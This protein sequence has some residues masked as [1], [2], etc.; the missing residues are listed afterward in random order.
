MTTPRR[1][2]P[3]LIETKLS[4]MLVISA[5]TRTGIS[6]DYTLELFPDGTMRPANGYYTVE[7]RR[8]ACARAINR[9]SVILAPQGRRWNDVLARV[10][11]PNDLYASSAEADRGWIDDMAKQ[12]KTDK[13]LRL[14]RY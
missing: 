8:A 3:K 2:T 6:L 7:D 5:G 13:D 14:P 11:D 12:M 1:W 10:E 4:D 9:F